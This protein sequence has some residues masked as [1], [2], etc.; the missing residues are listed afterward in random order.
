MT[1]IDD[2]LRDSLRLLEQR[3]PLAPPDVAP[4]PR[5]HRW[6]AVLQLGSVAAVV[7]AVAGGAVFLGVR[8]HA[9][10]PT[11]PA[12]P[13]VA[14]PHKPPR[15]DAEALATLHV[16]VALFG[17]PVRPN[18]RSRYRDN[19]PQPGATVRVTSVPSGTGAYGSKLTLSATTDQR[20]IASFSVP[21]GTY[22]YRW[23]VFHSREPVRLAAGSSRTVELKCAVP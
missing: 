15:S 17:G 21:P 5:R 2:D 20:G 7:L 23:D 11:A 16:R 14:E 9:D 22:A 18:G 10:R 4:G 3:A 19:R 12:G 1:T 6:E 13:S 8:H